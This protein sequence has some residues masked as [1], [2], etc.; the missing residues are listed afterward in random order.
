MSLSPQLLQLVQYTSRIKSNLS[1][2][3]SSIQQLSIRI[4]QGLENAIYF[5]THTITIPFHTVSRLALPRW[6]P[7]AFWKNR[8]QFHRSYISVN[9]V[10]DLN[11]IVSLFI[12]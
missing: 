3:P 4:I 1:S 12:D 6:L 11:G 7:K 9:Q 2:R 5:H 10:D 8:T